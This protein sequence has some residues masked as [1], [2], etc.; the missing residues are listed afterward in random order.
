MT[1]VTPTRSV[2]PQS[3]FARRIRQAATK[4]EIPIRPVD[5]FQH[6]TATGV[7]TFVAA[8]FAAAAG[9]TSGLGAGGNFA[10][11]A[12]RGR[13][14]WPGPVHAAAE[15]H[16]F[17]AYVMRCTMTGSTYTVFGY[18]GKQVRDAI[19]SRDLVRAFQRFFEEPRVGE[20]YNIG[21]GRSSNCSV[22]RTEASS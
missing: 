10:S 1:A 13:Y 17:L 15:L 14:Q 11:W 2:A 12:G 4:R 18:G 19:H 3:P 20:V 22:M 9:G 21:G 5:Q 8:P 6:T 7:A 16:G